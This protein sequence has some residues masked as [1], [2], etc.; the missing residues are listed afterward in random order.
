MLYG[1]FVPIDKA[2]IKRIELQADE[3]AVND[4]TKDRDSAIE[5]LKHLCNNDLQRESHIWD[6]SQISYP[7][8]TM[9]ER[10]EELKARTGYTK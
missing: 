1:E 10:I 8:M 9:G 3:F 2:H 5:C 7:V 4:I 6:I